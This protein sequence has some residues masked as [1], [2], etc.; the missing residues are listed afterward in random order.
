M[1]PSAR[2]P[3]PSAHGPGADAGVV[4]V[5]L[6]S[7]TDPDFLAEAGWNPGMRVLSLPS[8]HPLL[9]WRSC[10][11]A[12][13]GNP[14]YGR[15]QECGACRRASAAKPALPAGSGPAAGHGEGTRLAPAASADRLCQVAACGRE[16]RDRR[17]CRAHDERV[18]GL[19]SGPS[20][21]EA[22]WQATE[23]AIEGPGQVSLHGVSPRAAAEVLYGL[24]QR[25]RGGA[26]TSPAQMR[27]IAWELRR[28]R[29]AS[30]EE[31]A[32]GDRAQHRLARC[33]AKHV[34][35]ALLAP[36]TEIRKDV[37]DLAVFGLPGRLTFTVISQPWLRETARQWAADDLPRRRGKIAAAPVSHYLTSL[38]M[39]SESLRGARADHGGDPALLGRS[40]IESFVHRLTFLA[41]QERISA[42]ARTRTC[43]EIRHLLRQ[44]RALGLTR[45]CGPAAGLPDDFAVRD[46]DIPLKPDQ[47]E[48]GRDL[49]PEIMRQVCAHLPELEDL[50]CRETRVAAEVIIDTG[51]RP[52][53]ICALPWDCLVYDEPGHEPVLVY[54]NHKSA[55]QGRRLPIAQATAELIIA[56]KARVRRMFPGTALAELKLLPAAY[57]NPHGQRPI[58]EGHFG[59]RHRE[60]I[61]GLPPLLRADGTEFDKARVIPY[62][63]RHT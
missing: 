28:S 40:D 49:P 10:P 33:L 12:G 34:A 44:F 15:D 8:A 46:G 9:G 35:R 17:Y 13:C 47:P 41:Q 38:A 26:S 57:A 20:F 61:A 52:D 48:A 39:L 23:P 63:Y 24:Q 32:D 55:R 36:E 7:L 1:M 54:Y 25:T 21:N 56:Q 14:L 27:Q 11:S 50:S 37:W 58:A 30:L 53:E 51:R 18:R 22:E 16:R 29:S 62:A 4:V 3:R 60:W 59:S 6:T 2:T 43:R 31:I 19:R 42:D 45:A 5:R